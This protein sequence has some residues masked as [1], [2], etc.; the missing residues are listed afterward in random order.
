MGEHK[1]GIQTSGN[2]SAEPM[3]VDTPGGRVHVRWDMETG[4]VP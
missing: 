4:L 3:V 2:E 1:R